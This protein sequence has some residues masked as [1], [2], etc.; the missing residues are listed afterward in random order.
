MIWERIKYPINQRLLR[1]RDGRRVRHDRLGR[2]FF[3]FYHGIGRSAEALGHFDE[4]HAYA[5]TNEALFGGRFM[6][7]LAH[8][9]AVAHL[10][11]ASRRIA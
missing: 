3:E 5:R 2:R 4:V 9:R 10:G 7:T 8:Y 1:D 11:S 6:A